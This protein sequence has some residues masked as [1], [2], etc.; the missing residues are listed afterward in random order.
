MLWIPYDHKP[1]SPK[2]GR[3]SG[4]LCTSFLPWSDVKAGLKDSVI[5]Q[6]K[7]TVT[8]QIRAESDTATGS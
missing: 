7:P 8:L 3:I 6:Q 4:E 1:A 5:R 2:K